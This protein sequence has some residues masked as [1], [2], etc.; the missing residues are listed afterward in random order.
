MYQS[1][2]LIY[3][4]S[5]NIPMHAPVTLSTPLVKW[6]L[7]LDLPFLNAVWLPHSQLWVTAIKEKPQ[8]FK[9]I[10]WA[11]LINPKVFWKFTTSRPCW[12]VDMVYYILNAPL[13]IWWCFYKICFRFHHI[14]VTFN[15]TFNTIL[16]LLIMHIGW[17][18]A[19][20]SWW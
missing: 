3:P 4:L 9:V 6:I 8:S 11:I 7:P 10:H 2:S 1:Q 12:A 17:N 5:N 15:N 16:E 18:C 19:C 14:F 13:R 20:A